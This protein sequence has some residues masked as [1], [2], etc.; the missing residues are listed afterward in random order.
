M[1]DLD[2]SDAARN[3]CLNYMYNISSAGNERYLL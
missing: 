1:S 3:I 2:Q